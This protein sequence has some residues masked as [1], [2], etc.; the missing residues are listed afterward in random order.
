MIA[1]LNVLKQ[2]GGI[3]DREFVASD[4][5]PIL[6]NQ[7]LGPLL[8]LEQFHSFME[9]IKNLSSRVEQE[10]TKALQEM[11]GSN[12]VSKPNGNDDFMSFG[13]TTGFPTNNGAGDGTEDDFERLVKGNSSNGATSG[14]AMD[15]S[16]DTALAGQPQTA[17]T[18]SQPA[19][20]FAW[21]TPSPTTPVTPINMTMKQPTG[22][23]SRTITPDLSRFEALSPST[24]QFSQPLQPNNSNNMSSSIQPQIQPTSVN[25]GAAAH[26]PWGSSNT[27][28]PTTTNQ[29]PWGNATAP[30]L[31]SLGAMNNSMATMSMN[32]SNSM[33]NMSMN[34]RPPTNTFSSFSLPPPPTTSQ[35]AF[36]APQ[37]QQ[38]R[39][40]QPPP[41]VGFNNMQAKPNNNTQKSGL[42]KFESLL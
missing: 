10:H 39:A 25:W 1:A 37:Q 11:M 18:L 12:A 19:A 29:I 27:L 38:Q 24:T 20:R 33:S 8:N 5:L 2:V 14:G 22:P 4:I 16:W 9:L 17:N 28:M 23:T 6:W 41:T 31:S 7:A 35:N 13:G 30:S 26:N 21:S 42:D 3:A 40:F 36:Q 15:S 32:P 34:P